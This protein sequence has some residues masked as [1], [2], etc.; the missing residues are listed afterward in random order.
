MLAP[1][2]PPG[3]TNLWA[4]YADDAKTHPLTALTTKMQEDERCRAMGGADG[5]AA[6]ERAVQLAAVDGGGGVTPKAV[7]SLTVH[8]QPGSS[9]GKA[10]GG[11]C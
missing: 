2:P 4:A 7:Y 1:R 8:G 11:A 9:G 10:G 6:M 3:S 5:P